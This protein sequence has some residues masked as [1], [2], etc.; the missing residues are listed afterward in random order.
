M[1]N[2]KKFPSVALEDADQLPS[3][4]GIYFAMDGNYVL[5]VGQ[6]ENIRKRW[7]SHHRHRDIRQSCDNVR[8][9]FV[10]SD[11]RSLLEQEAEWIRACNPP[12]NGGRMAIV[13]AVP[14]D[15]LYVPHMVI[16]LL[17]SVFGPKILTTAMST[18]SEFWYLAA[19]GSAA[20]GTILMFYVI[21]ALIGWNAARKWW[22]K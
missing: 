22:R 11:G 9:H 14:S 15:R 18:G 17:I 2:P 8:I 10:L 12:F 3:L 6:S 13:P 16:I 1:T 20:L 4:P 5:Y 21:C 7:G 19:F